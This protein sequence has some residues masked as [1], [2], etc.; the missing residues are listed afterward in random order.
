MLKLLIRNLICGVYNCIN[1]LDKNLLG[2]LQLPDTSSFKIYAYE[3]HN[4]CGR[5][6]VISVVIKGRS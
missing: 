6:Q 5:S 1:F 2:Y 3:V 4:P